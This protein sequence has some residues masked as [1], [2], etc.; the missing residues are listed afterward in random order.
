MAGPRKTLIFWGLEARVAFSSLIV[1][2]LA[3]FL[4]F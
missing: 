1:G 4:G 2:F 3:E